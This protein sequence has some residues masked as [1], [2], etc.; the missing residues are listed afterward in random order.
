VGES[1]RRGWRCHCP[2]AASCRLPIGV[3]G[4]TAGRGGAGGRASTVPVVRVHRQLGVGAD[5]LPSML[6]R[7]AASLALG[8]LDVNTLL[9][10]A[11]PHGPASRWHL[12]V[13]VPLAQ[14]RRLHQQSWD[15]IFCILHFYSHILHILHILVHIRCIS[16]FPI[17]L[18]YFAYFN[19]YS[20]YF[21]RFFQRFF[22]I[23]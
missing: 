14:C 4:G 7:Y 13:T 23:F 18:A 10:V 12:L 2:F 21:Q 19:A 1:C 17:Y 16:L 5:P 22:H 3:G 11:A 20:A 6:V 8:A 15:C 9:N